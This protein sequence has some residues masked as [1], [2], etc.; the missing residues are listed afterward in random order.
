MVYDN[1]QEC[2]TVCNY[3]TDIHTYV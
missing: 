1:T 3:K 2:M